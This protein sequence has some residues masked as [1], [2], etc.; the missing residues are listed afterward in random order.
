MI[1]TKKLDIYDKIHELYD[2]RG[3][4]ELGG[5]ED[6]I[7]R[8]HEKG[9]MTARERIDVLVDEGSFVEINPFMEHRSPDL[10]KGPGDG[11]VTGFAK[12]HG[13]PVYL[14]SQDFTVFGGALGEMHAKKIANVMDLAAKTVFRLL[15]SMIRVVREYKKGSFPLTDMDM[16]FTVMPF[17]P[18]SS[19]KFRLLWGHVQV[20][21]CIRRQLRILLLWSKKRVK[22]LLPVRKSLKR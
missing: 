12:I 17:T 21:L 9:K 6:K 11:V 8:Q 20:V 16:F 10:P 15:D 18:V 22:C 1:E 3:E 13:R 4:V 2:K 19:R 7:D 5:G 14:F